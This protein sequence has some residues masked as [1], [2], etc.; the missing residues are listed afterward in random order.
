MPWSYLDTEWFN[1]HGDTYLGRTIGTCYADTLA[2]N[3]YHTTYIWTTPGNATSD[4]GF[5]NGQ[6]GWQVCAVSPW[7]VNGG[8]AKRLFSNVSAPGSQWWTHYEEDR[9]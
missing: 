6:W 2:P 1:P 4:I 7:C 9:P 3:R 5:V 8:Q